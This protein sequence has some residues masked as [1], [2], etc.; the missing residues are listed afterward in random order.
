MVPRGGYGDGEASLGDIAGFESI[1][2]I[3]MAK[4]MVMGSHLYGFGSRVRTKRSFACG[5]VAQGIVV[6]EQLA[7]M[8]TRCALKLRCAH[9]IN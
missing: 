6:F 2:T 7:A 9:Q 5:G 3:N 4:Q 8:F 1:T